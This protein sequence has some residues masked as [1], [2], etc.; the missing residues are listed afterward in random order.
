M[1]RIFPLSVTFKAV[2]DEVSNSLIPRAVFGPAVAIDGRV[3]SL[4]DVAVV[5]AMAFVFAKTQNENWLLGTTASDIVF[6][7]LYEKSPSDK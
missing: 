5:G 2:P 4:I 3:T 1:D 7:T 6:S